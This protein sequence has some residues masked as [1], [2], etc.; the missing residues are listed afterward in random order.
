[1]KFIYAIFAILLTIAATLTTTAFAKPEPGYHGHHGGHH[2]GG[3]GHGHGGHGGGFGRGG[4][5]GRFG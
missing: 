4:F 3:H 2:G 1:M 5:G